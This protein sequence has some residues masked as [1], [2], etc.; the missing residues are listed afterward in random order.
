MEHINNVHARIQ[1]IFSG[2]SDGYLSLPGGH[3]IDPRMHFIRLLRV[4][5]SEGNL[6][7]QVSV[8]TYVLSLKI[9]TCTLYLI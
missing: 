3:S 7:P 4:D 8:F 2:G 6:K 1:K 5:D 9:Y